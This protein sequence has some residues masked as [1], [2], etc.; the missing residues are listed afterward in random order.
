MGEKAAR[1]PGRIGGFFDWVNSRVL[2]VTLGVVALT[3]VAFP[4][5][6]ARSQED[7]DFDPTGEIY[8]TAALVDENF[9]N[10]S[11]ITDAL[12]IVEDRDGGDA[13]TRSVLLEVRQNSVAVRNDPELAPDLGVQFRGDL[14][15][16]V[17]G[18]FSLADEVD[19]MIA[20]RSWVSMSPK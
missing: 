10:S 19:S 15:R 16:E 9:Q 11:P 1:E 6:N 18:V 5:A 20:G 3:V 12:F 4:L 13:L 8:E 7:P 14:Q 17:D 2:P